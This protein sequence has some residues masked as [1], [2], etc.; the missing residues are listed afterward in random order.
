M[1]SISPSAGGALADRITKPDP[2]STNTATDDQPAS[3]S[4]ADEVSSPVSSK[5]A[6]TD[7]K[8]NGENTTTTTEA[9][10]ASIPQFDGATAPFMGSELREPEFEVDVKL[11]DMQADP[12]N[13]LY[14]A[15]SFDDLGL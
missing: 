10:E 3:T 13:P 9:K 4:W 2:S 11:A 8:T 15:K 14:S 5:P 6:S 12:N 7:D 1:A